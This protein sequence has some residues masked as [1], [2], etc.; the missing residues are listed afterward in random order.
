MKFVGAICFLSAVSLAIWSP[1]FSE[2]LTS[3][4]RRSQA[5]CTFLEGD[6][7]KSASFVLRVCSRSGERLIKPVSVALLGKGVVAVEMP[8]IASNYTGIWCSLDAPWLRKGVHSR[9][10]PE[11]WKP[12]P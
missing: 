12:I 6:E 4:Q 7:S 1:A 10:S 8:G 2:T 5:G 3:W 9:C 11:G